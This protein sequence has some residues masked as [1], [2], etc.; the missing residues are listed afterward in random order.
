MNNYEF[1]DTLE[2][3]E[4]TLESTP[5]SRRRPKFVILLF[6][7]F[8]IIILITI[9]ICCVLLS[10]RKA[11]EP[12]ETEV[13]TTEASDTAETEVAT[14]EDSKPYETE[15]TTSETSKT[16]ETEVATSKASEP[17]EPEVTEL[18]PAAVTAETVEVI[19]FHN[20]KE[21]P[22]IV[23]N[24]RD[25]EQIISAPTMLNWVHDPCTFLKLD[26][27][28]KSTVE[29]YLV[30]SSFE[31]RIEKLPLVCETTENGFDSKIIF[32]MTPELAGTLHTK[33]D[34]ASFILNADFYFEIVCNDNSVYTS[35][36]Y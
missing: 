14:S 12:S 4:C 33:E 9:I 16:Y 26:I 29:V 13:A 34:D 21:I 1:E 23:W 24:A 35:V 6:S 22:L 36:R 8:G 20:N 27:Y 3:S 28:S 32:E 30:N 18:E 2:S 7:I 10:K 5:K 31:Q 11:S 15:T 17:A 25:R 19:A